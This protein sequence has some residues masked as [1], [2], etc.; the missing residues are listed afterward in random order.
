MS[1]EHI[2]SLVD[3]E[4]EQYRLSNKI[5]SHRR[6]RSSLDK[7]NWYR[8]ANG[9]YIKKMTTTRWGIEVERKDWATSWLPR[10]K[11][12]ETNL[13]K[14]ASYNKK[15]NLIDEQSFAW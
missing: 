10:K 7:V 3:Y 11:I 9:K 6:K 2:F 13:V 8:I 1:L 4:G 14:L 12:K 5:I 15:N